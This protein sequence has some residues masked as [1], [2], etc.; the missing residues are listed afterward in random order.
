M[1]LKIEFKSEKKLVLAHIFFGIN[2]DEILKTVWSLF[3]FQ[4][5]RKPYVR[6]QIKEKKNHLN[7]I[8]HMSIE[9]F[10]CMSAKCW[11]CLA[12]NFVLMIT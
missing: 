11:L 10:I 4:I 7:T 5:E 8:E 1:Y 6:V 9:F 2:D 12:T 3:H